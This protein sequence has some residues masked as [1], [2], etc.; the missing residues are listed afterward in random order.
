MILLFH[1]APL[2]CTC[3][4][5]SKNTQLA[6]FHKINKLRTIIHSCN[7]F[8][9]PI[10]MLQPSSKGMVNGIDQALAAVGNSIGP[11]ASAPI[12]AWS[13]KTSEMN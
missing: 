3:I 6:A 10:S 2:A 5:L 9:S 12:F 11:V 1:L 4:C 7:N 8:I 13:E